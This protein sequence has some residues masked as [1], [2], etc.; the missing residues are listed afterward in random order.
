ML[1]YLLANWPII[2]MRKYFLSVRT[3]IVGIAVVCTDSI[4]VHSANHARTHIDKF[5]RRSRPA[6]IYANAFNSGNCDTSSWS[7]CAKQ[8]CRHSKSHY[9]GLHCRMTHTARTTLLRSSPK[10]PPILSLMAANALPTVWLVP[11]SGLS[12]LSSRTSNG[13]TAVMSEAQT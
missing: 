2:E 9:D 4:A 3:T 11:S 8:V 7:N 12:I 5:R 1:Q 6:N 13:Y 10:S